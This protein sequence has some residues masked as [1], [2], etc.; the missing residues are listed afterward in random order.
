MPALSRSPA[1]CSVIMRAAYPLCLALGLLT[2]GC[3]DDAG[4]GGGDAEET[5][6]GTAGDAADETGTGSADAGDPCG[7]CDDDDPCTED[8]CEANGSCAVFGKPCSCGVITA[9]IGPG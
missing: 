3:S 9:P 4:Q 2:L 1:L 8:T 7:G 6:D 5:A